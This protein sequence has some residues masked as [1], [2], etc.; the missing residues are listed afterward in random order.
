MC[1]IAQLRSVI[2]SQ[3][4]DR[5]GRI[6]IDIDWL[7]VNLIRK[8]EI[9]ADLFLHILQRNLDLQLI[10]RQIHQNVLFTD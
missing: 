4:D 1:D 6:G 3:T 10:L 7:A 8:T 9:H 5:M 2:E